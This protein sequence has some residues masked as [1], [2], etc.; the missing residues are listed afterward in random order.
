[1]VL[2]LILNFYFDKRSK[3]AIKNYRYVNFHMILII[4]DL[5]FVGFV[6]S[7]VRNQT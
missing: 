7:H 3:A 4:A 2:Y 5:L 6:L 1:M